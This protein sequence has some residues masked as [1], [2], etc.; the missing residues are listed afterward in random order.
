MLVLCTCISDL[1]PK[2]KNLYCIF[3]MMLILRYDCLCK[4]KGVIC[5]VVKA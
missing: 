1:S 3:C 4:C 2:V 5:F